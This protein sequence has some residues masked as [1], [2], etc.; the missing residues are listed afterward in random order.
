MLVNIYVLVDPRT[1]KVRYIGR[2]RCTLKKRLGEHVCVDR[3]KRITRVKSWIKSLKAINS[4]PYIRLLTTCEGWEESHALEQELIERHKEKH[5]L[6]NHRDR[7]MGNPFPL[8]S[9]FARLQISKTLKEG[10][11]SG[12]L[13]PTKVKPVHVYSLAGEFIESYPSITE[14][15]KVMGISPDSIRRSMQGKCKQGKGFLFRDIKAEEVTPLVN[16]HKGEVNSFKVYC[17]DEVLQFEGIPKCA[18]HFNISKPHCTLKYFSQQLFF[19]FPDVNY[20]ECSKHGLIKRGNSKRKVITINHGGNLRYFNSFREVCTFYNWD[21]K[22][23]GY[24]AEFSKKFYKH[25]PTS[26]LTI[27]PHKIS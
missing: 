21:I 19:D 22:Q 27:S 23:F 12:R 4:K 15:S 16:F 1:L 18:K 5:D 3:S 8:N 14:C 10:Y 11:A 13:K 26:T 2:T 9:D 7:G 24:K 17:K 20:I 25:F 6:L